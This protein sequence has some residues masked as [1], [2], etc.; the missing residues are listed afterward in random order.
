MVDYMRQFL[1]LSKNTFDFF[2]SVVE[3]ENSSTDEIKDTRSSREEFMK[4][5]FG[6]ASSSVFVHV[7]HLTLVTFLDVHVDIVMEF[8]P[9]LFEMRRSTMQLVQSVVDYFLTDTNSSNLDTNDV[10]NQH[11]CD[12]RLDEVIAESHDCK[13]QLEEWNL[14]LYLNS[15]ATEVITQKLGH[16]LNTDSKDAA[17][18]SYVSQKDAAMLSLA[19]FEDI[20][21]VSEEDFFSEMGK[22]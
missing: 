9:Y 7:V 6:P 20:G 8:L 2:R 16:V 15:L 17:V 12:S 13:S 21:S 18:E 22:P 11:R 4:E 19:I 10:A 1:T 14:L 3:G 5:I